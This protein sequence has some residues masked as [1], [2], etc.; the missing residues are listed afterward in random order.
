MESMTSLLP[1]AAAIAVVSLGVG[2]LFGFVVR[3]A[4]LRRQVDPLH[5]EIRNLK[6]Q[7]ISVRREP[8]KPPTARSTRWT[9]AEIAAILAACGTLLT[10]LAGAVV[11]YRALLVKEL[12]TQ[13]KELQDRSAAQ[14]KTYSQLESASV[15]LLKYD[16]ARWSRLSA[17]KETIPLARTRAG[18][19]FQIDDK[20]I[21]GKCDDGKEAKLVYDGDDPAILRCTGKSVTLLLSRPSKLLILGDS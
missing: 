3:G 7:L 17:K 21:E 15:T 10:G 4:Q 1:Y 11:S 6:E 12:Q 13:V 20:T 8:E 2:F 19:P 18:R 9:G 5:A 14:D 16:I